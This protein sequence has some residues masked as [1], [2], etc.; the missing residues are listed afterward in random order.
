AGPRRAPGRSPRGA[1]LDRLRARGRSRLPHLHRDGARPLRHPVLLLPARPYAEG[2][3][4]RAPRLAPR[5]VRGSAGRGWMKPEAG[6]GTVTERM[7][8]ANGVE[9]C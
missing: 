1:R 8:E 6:N 9:L 3:P 5:R 2:N 7:I 4:G